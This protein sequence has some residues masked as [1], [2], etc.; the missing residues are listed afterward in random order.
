ME[1]YYYYNYPGQIQGQHPHNGGAVAGGV[2]VPMGDM[3]MWDQFL[4]CRKIYQ[5]MKGYFR[6]QVLHAF[7]KSLE[8]VVLVSLRKG[9]LVVSPSSCPGSV[10]GVV[11]SAGNRPSLQS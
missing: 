8:D 4:G 9:S 6:H 3:S 11:A 2:S 10:R 7:R 5:F 1:D